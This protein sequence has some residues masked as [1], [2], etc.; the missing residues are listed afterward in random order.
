[1]VHSQRQFD[2]LSQPFLMTPALAPFDCMIG[3]TIAF[4]EFL[5]VGD[6]S[7]F[8]AAEEG[9]FDKRRL[10]KMGFFSASAPQ[11]RRSGWG[12]RVGI[13]CRLSLLAANRLDWL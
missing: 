13:D 5:R 7:W 3:L 10:G 1:M 11:G 2:R 8:S 4:L 6:A 12:L 9:I